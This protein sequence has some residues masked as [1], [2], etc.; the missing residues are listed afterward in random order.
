MK[1]ILFKRNFGN[2]F[3]VFCEQQCYIIN[4]C[5]RLPTLQLT[6]SMKKALMRYAGSFMIMAGRSTWMELT[7]ML[8]LIFCSL[9]GHLLYFVHYA[10]TLFKSLLFQKGYGTHTFV[11][12]CRW[13]FTWQWSWFFLFV[14][15][16]IVINTWDKSI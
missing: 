16:K 4:I 11:Q 9:L 3:G 2:S 14:E 6:E 8:R 5:F 13:H 15:T 7:W 1:L 12:E 10:S